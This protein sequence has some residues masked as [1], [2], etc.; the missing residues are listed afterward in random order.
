MKNRLD[1]YLKNVTPPPRAEMGEGGDDDPEP[2]QV[3]TL[4][5]FGAMAAIMAVALICQAA[6]KITEMFLAHS[7]K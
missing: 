1:E 3:P 2:V 6:I 5:C 4:G 7:A